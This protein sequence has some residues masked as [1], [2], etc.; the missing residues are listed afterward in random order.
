MTGRGIDQILQHPGDSTLHECY[1]RDA[2]DYITLAERV[3]GPIDRRAD[4]SYIW[5]DA[6]PEL[7]SAALAARIINLETSITT[8]NQ[9]WPKGINYRMHPA[10]VTCLTRAKIDCCVLANNHVIDWGYGGLEETIQ[11][12]KQAGIASAG[13][14]D[15]AEEAAAPAILPIDAQ[16]RILVFAGGAEDSGIPTRWGAG[17]DLPGV[18][19]LKDFSAATVSRIADQVRRFKSGQD[20]AV[21]SIH[22]GGNWGYETPEEQRR[23]AHQL[24]DEAAIDVVHGHSSHHVKGLEVYRDKPI[25]YGAGDLLNDY[26]GIGGY[27]VFRG[28]LALLYFVAI[29]PL[30][31]RLREWRL[32]PMQ[33]RRFQLRRASPEDTRWLGQTLNREGINLGTRVEAGGEGDL[34]VRW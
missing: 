6:L 16:S 9:P 17:D 7:E 13:A 10:N 25:L 23:F 20:L 26:E 29:D 1:V 30:T 31:H 2:R 27:E 19:L 33:M 3:S 22:W 21:Y 14:G 5:G 34:Y 28:D 4:A 24:I 15:D 8:S 18:N 11:V 12:L 32:V